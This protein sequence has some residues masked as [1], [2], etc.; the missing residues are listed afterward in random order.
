M[1][2][3]NNGY[4]TVAYSSQFARPLTKLRTVTLVSPLPYPRASR[5]NERRRL[6]LLSWRNCAVRA[7]LRMR[8]SPRQGASV[9]LVFHARAARRQWQQT[10]S[11]CGHAHHTRRE[12]VLGRLAALV[13]RFVRCVSLERGLSETAANAAGGKIYTYG[14]YRLGVHGPG[15]DI[16][17]L[18]VVPRHVTREDFFSVLEPM[19]REMEG[20][21][22]VS[23]RTRNC[24]ARRLSFMTGM[25]CREYRKH[26]FLSSRLRYL[27]SLSTWCSPS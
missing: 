8:K 19:L 12:I 9:D 24:R 13:K 22:G 3:S 25:V 6:L 7:C 15:T 27:V 2:S 5:T 14:S 21:T 18:C 20:V 17:T 1:A 11:D 23:V 16:D 10:N 4:D 26:M